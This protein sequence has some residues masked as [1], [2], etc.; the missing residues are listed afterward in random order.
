MNLVL[1]LNCAGLFLICYF[2][3]VYFSLYAERRSYN[4]YKLL[5]SDCITVRA[6]S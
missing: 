1:M 5:T 2:C 3:T 6:C 4:Y